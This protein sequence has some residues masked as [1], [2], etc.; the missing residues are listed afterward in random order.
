MYLKI[1]GNHFYFTLEDVGA[2]PISDADHA[3]FLKRQASERIEWKVKNTIPDTGG[4][5]DYIESVELPP[6]GEKPL[7]DIEQ[8]Q[9]A[10]AEAVEKQE[11][12]KIELQLAMA[13]AI[14]MMLGGGE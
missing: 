12:D 1:E 7:T 10:V 3:Q 13:E 2:V 11:A 5:F 4:L 9:L 6:D 8:T 14:E